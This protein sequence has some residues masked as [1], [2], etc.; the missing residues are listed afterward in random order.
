MAAILLV[1]V[2]VAAYAAPV[3][4]SAA[5]P[6]V[7]AEERGELRQT[8]ESRYEVLPVSGGIA[9]KPRQPRAGIRTIEVTGEEVAVNGERVNP[10]TLRD[11]L[12]EDADAILRLRGLSTDEQ[13]QVFGLGEEAPAA[14]R[15]EPSV[16]ETPAMTAGEE[17]ATSD[18]DVAEV[19]EPPAAPA[20]PAVPER[21]GRRTSSSRVNVGGSVRVDKDEI[22]DAAV[23]VGGSVTVDGEVEDEVA[24]IGGPAHIQGRVGGDVISVGSSVHLGPKAVVDGNVTSVGGR[25]RREPGSVIHGET[26]EVGFF[27]WE[28]HGRWL[29]P[30]WG[31]WGGF[32]GGVSDVM[33]SLT[34]LVLMGLLVSLTLLVARRPLE[35]V[36]RQLAAQP[37]QS[38]AVGLA[39]VV[40]FWPL[41]FVVTILLLIT[42][43][44][45]LLIALYPFLF[46]WV[47]LLLL[48]GYAAVVYRVGR[49]LESRFNRR[50]GGPYAAAL[51]G[52]L[53]IQGWLVLG[54][55]L[56]LLPGP[57]GTMVWLFGLLLVVAAV[58]VGFGAVIL[59]RFGLE[60]GYWPRRGAPAP[61][62]SYTPPPAPDSLPLTDPLTAP[63]WEEPRVYPPPETE[64]PR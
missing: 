1:L 50:F 2:A 7:S 13:R 6:P 16:E 47:A 12:G 53:A 29:G 19:P 23:A 51:M 63:P 44:G 26:A 35:R 20:E 54:N 27:P 45:C 11:W 4:Q 37:W 61:P 30:G 15:P 64:P 41:L 33:G 57:F 34:V 14:G 21:P 8:I 5:N 39:G 9:L 31:L 60:P 58:I 18:V 46:L 49:W 48:L 36:D 59:A 28:R 17:A 32:L 3:P 62:P 43:V 40:F 10:R 55:L 52:L 42:I 38:A 22:V 25:I 24:A 56:D